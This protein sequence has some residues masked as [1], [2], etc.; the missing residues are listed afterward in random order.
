[1]RALASQR[2]ALLKLVAPIL[3]FYLIVSEIAQ[4]LLFTIVTYFVTATGK[5]GVEFGNT[6]NEIAD[7][8]RIFSYALGVL[9]AAITIWLGDKALYRHRPFWN[10][11]KKPF[12]QLDRFT[13]EELLRGAS[14]GF[15]AAFVYLAIFTL[16]RQ[17]SFLGMLITSSLGTPVFPLFFLDFVSLIV[18]LACD[19]FIFRHKILRGLLTLLSPNKA[20]VLTS[21]FYVFAKH[22]QFSLAP[23]D[24]LNLFCLNAALGFFYL[25]AGKSHRGLGFLVFLFGTLHPMAGLPLWAQESPSFFLFKES[26]R[27]TQLLSGGETGPLGGLGLFSI[28][29]VF[30]IGG[31]YSWKRGNKSSAHPHAQANT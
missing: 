3:I 7:Q 2:Y 20:V 15:L 31:H 13:K 24:Y 29:L 16:S 4:T 19:E 25:K 18:L 10:D 26:H 6:V 9:L 5:S 1:M 27:A 21:V 28:L 11:P 8:Y 12:W 22:L 17:L 30:T 23:I 14:S